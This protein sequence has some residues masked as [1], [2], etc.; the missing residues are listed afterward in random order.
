[1]HETAVVERNPDLVRPEAGEECLLA[2]HMPPAITR[3]V[4]QD[5]QFVAPVVSLK[6]AGGNIG[7][8][9][10]GEGCDLVEDIALHEL[11]GIEEGFDAFRD[12]VSEGDREKGERNRLVNDVLERCV[13]VVVAATA[14]DLFEVVDGDGFKKASRPSGVVEDFPGLIDDRLYDRN[15]GGAVASFQ[16]TDGDFGRDQELGGT[17]LE[18][19]SQG[20]LRRVF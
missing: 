4:R 15:S 13:V 6:T 1:M 10:G 11:P 18:N 16:P 14:I 17:D 9:V 19:V 8:L 2:R 5:G 20:G 7:E 3:A 12:P